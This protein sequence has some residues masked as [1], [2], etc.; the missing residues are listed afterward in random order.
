MPTRG[1]NT[2][3][4]RFK[5]VSALVSSTLFEFFVFSCVFA[6]LLSCAAL[7]AKN[8]ENHKKILGVLDDLAF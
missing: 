7:L 3:L 8:G 4:E 2:E 1:Q 5:Q 6:Y